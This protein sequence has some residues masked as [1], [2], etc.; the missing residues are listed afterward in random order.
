MRPCLPLGSSASARRC[1]WLP[2]RSGGEDAG[3]KRP[4]TIEAGCAPPGLIPAVRVL[5]VDDER[6]IRKTLAICLQG[7]SCEVAESASSTSALEALARSA[8]DLAFVD[9]KL[10][11]E[12]G[13]ALVPKL[14]AERPGLDIVVITA[15]ATFDTAVEAIKRGARDYLP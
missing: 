9:L 8:Y 15:Y 14:L 5:I 10:G 11:R 1:S 4:M 3:T 12:D 7:L 2:W 6:N 13:L